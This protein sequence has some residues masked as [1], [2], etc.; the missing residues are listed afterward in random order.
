MKSLREKDLIMETK[1]GRKKVYRINHV[2]KPLVE[3]HIQYLQDSYADVEH[4]MKP[5]TAS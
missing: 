3:K 4:E 2:H 1:E 5:I